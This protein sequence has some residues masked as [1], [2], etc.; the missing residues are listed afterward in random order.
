MK[1]VAV[2]LI[3]VLLLPLGAFPPLMPN[4]HENL[5]VKKALEYAESV[6]LTK[7]LPNLS[8]ILKAQAMEDNS[9]K[10]KGFNFDEGT[11]PLQ[12]GIEKA[13]EN[14]AKAKS[15]KEKDDPGKPD[16]EDRKCTIA[17][18]KLEMGKTNAHF[19]EIAEE[20]DLAK[21]E[22]TVEDK[23]DI[24]NENGEK[25]GFMVKT[26]TVLS[27]DHPGQGHKKTDNS[28]NKQDRVS[29]DDIMLKK[30]VKDK[31]NNGKAKGQAQN[32]NNAAFFPGSGINNDKDC[33]RDSD[34]EHFGGTDV[35]DG[36]ENS[37]FEENGD[38]KEGFSEQ[39][40]EDPVDE[41]NND[42]DCTRISDGK[43][44]GG[45]VTVGDETFE[46]EDGTEFSC[47]DERG[48]LKDGFEP[49]VNEDGPDGIDNDDDGFIDEDGPDRI[50]NDGDGEIDEDP[51][52]L[53]LEDACED[54]GGTFIQIDGDCDLTG[55][56]ISQANTKHQQ[57]TRN[58][59]H[60]C[61]D[62]NGNRLGELESN[63]GSDDSCFNEDG[64]L[65]EI[66]GETVTPLNGEDPDDG[67]NDGINNDFDCVEVIEVDGEIVA[68]GNGK[69]L[70]GDPT[71]GIADACYDS[72][73][74]VK[75]GFEELVDED[76][77][78]EGKKFYKTHEDDSDGMSVYGKEQRRIV[79]VENL[80]VKFPETAQGNPQNV[81]YD[82]KNDF[83]T[84]ID[85]NFSGLFNI[86]SGKIP[87]AS[88]QFQLPRTD[89]ILFGFTI[90]PPDMKWG[91]D[92][93]EEVCTPAVKLFG[94]T[95]IPSF[96]LVILAV[97]IGYHISFAVGLRLPVTVTTRAIP[98]RL[99]AQ[100]DFRLETELVPKD[101]TYQEYFDLCED[102][103]IVGKSGGLVGSCDSFAFENALDPDDGDE[104]ALKYIIKAGVFVTI[105]NIDVISWGIN[106][107]IDLGSL[108]TTLLAKSKGLNPGFNEPNQFFKDHNANCASFTTPYGFDKLI[109][110]E[111]SIRPWPGTSQQITIQANCLDAR[112]SGDTIKIKG[113]TIPI[114]TGIILQKYGASL[115]LGLGITT[116]L[117]S[118]N[119]DAT[120]FASGDVDP[121]DTSVSVSYNAE[122][123]F[124]DDGHI[125]HIHGEFS[126]DITVDNWS[127]D[128]EFVEVDI[129]EFTYRLN[130]AQI[131][132]IAILDFGGIIGF[133]D[134]IPAFVLFEINVFDI[135][136]VPDGFPIP[137]HAWIDGT[138]NFQIPVD[139]YALRI[140][141]T[142]NSPKMQLDP[143]TASAPY[144]ITIENIG[145][146]I[147]SFNNFMINLPFAGIVTTD[148]D[149]PA[150]HETEQVLRDEFSD[151]FSFTLN[152]ER[153]FTT[154]PGDY[155]VEVKA[156]SK[157][158]KTEGLAAQ[159][160]IPNFRQGAPDTFIVEVLAFP[161]PLVSVPPDGELDDPPI[162]T[163]TSPGGQVT[164]AIQILNQGNSPDNI[165]L[166]NEFVDFNQESPICSL[167]TLGTLPDC[168][169]RAVPTLIQNGWTNIGEIPTETGESFC[170]VIMIDGASVELCGLEQGKSVIFDPE[171]SVDIPSDWAGMTLTIYQYN[172]TV[173]SNLVSS[174]NDPKI[175]T[176]DIA[177]IQVNPTKE[178][179]MRYIGLELTELKTELIDTN[180]NNGAIKGLLVILQK[181]VTDS[182][183]KA[184]DNVLADNF[185]KANK[186]L[187]S[188]QK[189]MSAF[190]SALNGIDGKNNKLG[191]DGDDW[192][193]SAEAILADIQTTIDFN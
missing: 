15:D 156:D 86:L 115:G 146:L 71:D 10:F 77:I 175:F 158:S 166:S 154:R 125:E 30:V 67:I 55:L 18:N 66:G 118:N 26:R 159:D 76:T 128:K 12:R 176:N 137:Q 31:G 132:G 174:T 145:T 111:P 139:N 117:G 32:Q 29:W 192:L 135:I 104:F 61:V 182:Y 1:I 188:M 138:D 122:D 121:D 47:F 64:S 102:Q 48:I 7:Y 183:D 45:L 161:N 186:N 63:H 160:P 41:I 155:T 124:N 3:V 40:D 59:D 120:L 17:L 180:L 119:I 100:D 82:D 87:E 189:Q 78:A 73:G 65:K 11:T 127:A 170:F 8:P 167:T 50:D 126:K 21:L 20:C 101:F 36:T 53:T 172:A 62:K 22:M 14:Q 140:D 44:F 142:P 52:E 24:M 147:D 116:S 193:A 191:P 46:I 162:T 95:I 177:Q 92:Y 98:T 84:M 171:L 108:C 94:K 35:E 131:I 143:G 34:R 157:N 105:L 190:V 153:V 148:D 43:H 69:I 16:P 54:N 68:K 60:D 141:A 168:P 42:G 163:P 58:P 106:S 173:T 13:I 96:C 89:N 164:Y 130:E 136:G 83:L 51:A 113:K 70:A 178:S 133:I 90:A 149:P 187:S 144:D 109:A 72:N 75:D 179:M 88:A 110:N 80:E 4:L 37:C 123:S 38:L 74:D 112:L 150:N 57:M 28:G 93:S 5:E 85:K 25:I 79:L 165:S 19:A 129:N 81:S 23:K 56:V 97:F 99:L 49:L 169:Y 151:P 107:S 39:I 91:I 103:G 2:L 181:P 152:A 134:D 114:C 185:N 9:G 6:G 27:F 184:F 33:T